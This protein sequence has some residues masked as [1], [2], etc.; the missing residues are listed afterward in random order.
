[1]L[2][3]KTQDRPANGSPEITYL[4]RSLCAAWFRHVEHVALF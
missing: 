1:M 3:A 2:P 4:Q